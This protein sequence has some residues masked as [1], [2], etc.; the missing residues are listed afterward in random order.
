MME[1]EEAEA[2]FDGLRERDR[3][4]ASLQSKQSMVG[5]FERLFDDRARDH[6][7]QRLRDALD[8]V[9]ARARMLAIDLAKAA[10]FEIDVDDISRISTRLRALEAHLDDTPSARLEVC[11]D[12]LV[13]L[14]EMRELRHPPRKLPRDYP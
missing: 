12:L 14:R 2:V 11:A 10:F 1:L 6:V 3:M 9:R 13:F 5:L 4:I 7:G 8:D